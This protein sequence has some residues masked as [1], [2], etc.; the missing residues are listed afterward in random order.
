[1]PAPTTI[2][3]RT[4]DGVP[5]VGIHRPAG[6]GG[7]PG[8][9][10]VL[11]HGFTNSTATPAFGR[12][13]TRL[14]RV[15]DVVA[16]DF[17]GHGGSGG[18]SSAGGD[19]EV[20]DLDAVVAWVRARGYRRVVTVGLSM[21]GGVV[22][23]HAALRGGLDAAVSVSAVS[24]WYVRDTQAMRRVHFLLETGVGRWFAERVLHTRLGGRWPTPP[25]SPIEI[26]HRIAPMPLLIVHGDR[27]RYFPVVHPYTLARAVGPSANL[28]VVPGFGHAESGLRPDLVDGIAGWIRGHTSPGLTRSGGE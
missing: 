27:D 4:A 28:W 16:A 13:S 11:C 21:G 1:M 23:R 18:R 17:R 24:R 2:R 10:V 26:V 25:S 8:V 12:I 19:D 5:L 22:L 3:L 20:T 6:A 7:D 14:T 9:A 15:G